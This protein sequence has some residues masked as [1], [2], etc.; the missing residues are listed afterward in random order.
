VTLYIEGLK[1]R[2]VTMEA[3]GRFPKQLLVPLKF[4]VLLKTVRT[5][6]FKTSNDASALAKLFL[7]DEVIRICKTHQEHYVKAFFL[8]AL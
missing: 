3:R 2:A 6:N 4:V 1:N 8:I 5:C 7:V